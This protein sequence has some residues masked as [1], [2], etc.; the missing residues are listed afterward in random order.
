M[1]A[2]KNTVQLIGN[3]GNDPEIKKKITEERLI[4][5]IFILKFLMNNKTI[6]II[7]ICKFIV[8]FL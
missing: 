2:M 8:N 1:N 7:K 3:V 4:R 6:L 5:M